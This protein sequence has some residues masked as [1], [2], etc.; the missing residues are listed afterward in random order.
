MFSSIEKQQKPSPSANLKSLFRFS[1]CRAR[2]D[3]LRK[4]DLSYMDISVQLSSE[5]IESYK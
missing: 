3:I 4:P 5:I 1:K 2:L